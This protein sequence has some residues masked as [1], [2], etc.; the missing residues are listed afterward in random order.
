MLY[1]DHFFV[2]ADCKNPM[3]LPDTFNELQRIAEPDERVFHRQ[4]VDNLAVVKSFEF[5]KKSRKTS[6]FFKQI[7]VNKST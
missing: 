3:V 2:A 4:F 6:G 1:D 5:T 7:F